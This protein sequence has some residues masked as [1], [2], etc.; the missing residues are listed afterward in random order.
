MSKI[1]FPK[2]FVI[3]SVAGALNI[4]LLWVASFVSPL[5]KYVTGV[6]TSLGNKLIEIFSGFAPFTATVPSIMIAA[7]GGGLLVWLG[8]YIHALPYTPNFK[9]EYMQLMAV[10]VYGAIGA[11]IVLALPGFALPAWSVLVALLIN[12]AATAWFI[13]YV[14]DK[15][16]G[17]VDV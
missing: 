17:I 16:L 4:V 1:D 7:V 2:W 11:T 13:V 3:G 5:S 10:L 12:A 14:L 9:G 15:G 6:D 8:K